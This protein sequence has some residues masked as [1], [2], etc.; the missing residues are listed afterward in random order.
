MSIKN[1]PPKNLPEASLYMIRRA[2]RL[3]SARR[4]DMARHFEAS[5]ASYTR[6]IAMALD[7]AA[8]MD[9]EGRGAGARLILAK[10]NDVP[11]WAGFESLLEEIESGNTSIVTGIEDYELPVFIPRWTRNSP[12]DHRALGKI[13]LAIH[14][15]QG[16]HLRYV[17]LN[18][19]EEGQWRCVYP[20]GLERMGDQWR[21]V[22]LD[23]EKD[24]CPLR[25]FVLARIIGVDDRPCIL[26]KGFSKPGIHDVDIAVRA[27]LNPLLTPDQAVVLSNELRI[28]DGM[29]TLNRRTLF[30]FYRRFG[31]QS[32]SDKAVWPPL[33]N[34]LE[35]GN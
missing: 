24:M 2:C 12:V 20:I 31:A 7:A 10:E 1:I 33:M 26:P 28:Q 23:L 13:I 5:Q 25:I 6:W 16:L 29:I 21:L 19:G 27:I 17:N 14:R 4:Q 35:N 3:G 8:C 11:W 22:A 32:L 9:R 30:E 34:T 18:R 15:E